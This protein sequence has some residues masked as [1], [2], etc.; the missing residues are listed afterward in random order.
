MKR[1]NFISGFVGAIAA[2][3]VSAR[4]IREEPAIGLPLHIE[5]VMIIHDCEGNETRRF[6]VSMKRTPWQEAKFRENLRKIGDYI[7]KRTA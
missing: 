1:R 7:W 3:A 4:L 5:G 2:A 6:A